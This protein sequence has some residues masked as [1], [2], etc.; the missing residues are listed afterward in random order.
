MTDQF[1]LIW[2][3]WWFAV[4]AVMAIREALHIRGAAS[5]G[6]TPV[7]WLTFEVLVAIFCAYR[8]ADVAGWL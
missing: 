2:Y 3:G 6:W 8:F 4:N 7:V 5:V 1:L